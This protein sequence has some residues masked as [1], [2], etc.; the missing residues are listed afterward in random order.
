MLVYRSCRDALPLLFLLFVCDIVLSV[1][2]EITDMPNLFHFPFQPSSPFSP[3]KS[4]HYDDKKHLDDEDNWS[5]TSSYPQNLKIL[6]V[7]S[8]QIN[9]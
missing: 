9:F 1:F 4:L 8:E 7:N 6:I 3:R 2:N 5:V